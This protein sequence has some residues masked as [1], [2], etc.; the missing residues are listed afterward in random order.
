MNDVVDDHQF[1]ATLKLHYASTTFLVN[2]I[3]TAQ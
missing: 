1:L 2:Y 3:F